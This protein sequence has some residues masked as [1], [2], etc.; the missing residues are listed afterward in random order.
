[1]FTGIISEV[2]EVA[3]VAVGG[4]GGRIKIRAAR[5]AAALAV[6]DSVAVEG[7]CLTAAAV[8]GEYF[9]ADVSRETAETTTLAGT[10][11][12]D[13]VN[14][15]L[16]TAVGAPLGGHLVQGHVDGVG[17]VRELVPSGD[18][19][20]L[21]VGVPT[22]ISRYVVEKGSVAVAGISLT[23]VAVGDGE[24]GAAIV[25]HTYRNTT[26]RHRRSGDRVNI[27]V[28]LIAKYVERFVGSSR[29]GLSAERLAELGYGG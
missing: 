7:A 26:L 12:G 28:D 18:G 20:T 23:A 13:A 21:R 1:M 11:T 9:E 16:A 22:G 4:A 25:P 3:G 29:G 17:T 8:D 15:E 24:F 27:E 19:Y 6:G 5:T 10:K 14:L 2:G